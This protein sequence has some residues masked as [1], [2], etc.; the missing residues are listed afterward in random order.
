[1]SATFVEHIE[2]FIFVEAFKIESVKEAIDGL[3]YCYFKIDIVPLEEM[4]KIYESQDSTIE[5]PV[6]RHWVRIKSGAYKDDLGQAVYDSQ[7]KFYVK[8]I[9]RLEFGPNK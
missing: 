9:P 3:N 2:N 6:H 5:R 7:G 4:T 8:L 1:M